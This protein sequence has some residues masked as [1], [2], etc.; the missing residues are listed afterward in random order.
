[1]KADQYIHHQ[2]NKL[3]LLLLAIHE[4]PL[5]MTN[6]YPLVWYPDFTGSPCTCELYSNVPGQLYSAI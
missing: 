6:T 2:Y 4:H 5:A 3:L 1:L